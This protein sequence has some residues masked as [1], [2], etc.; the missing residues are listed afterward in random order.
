M[1]FNL[2]YGRGSSS[3]TTLLEK[4][5]IRRRG[6]FAFFTSMI[7]LPKLEAVSYV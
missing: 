4:A 6:H 5:P 3:F 2:F 1:S 7:A